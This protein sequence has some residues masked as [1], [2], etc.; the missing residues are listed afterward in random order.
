MIG[1]VIGYFAGREHIK[2]ELRQTFQ[3]AAEGVKNSFSSALGGNRASSELEKKETPTP[4]FK[5]PTPLSVTL[6]KKGYQAAD[7]SAGIRDAITFAVTFNNLTGKD[8]RAFDGSLTFTDL[9]DN[10]LLS[11]KLAINDPVPSSSH[12]GWSGQIDYNQF[13]DKHQRLRNEDFQNLKIRFDT[14]KILFSDGS[15]KEFE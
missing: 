1:L 11:A 3:A 5:E 4:K 14:K 10:T 6:D 7:Y 9:L 8:I 13:I 12:L 2:F 15:V